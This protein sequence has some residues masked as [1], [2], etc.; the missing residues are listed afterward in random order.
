MAKRDKPKDEGTSLSPKAQGKPDALQRPTHPEPS[1]PESVKSAR[2]SDPFEAIID[3][4]L[5]ALE[6]GK[7][8]TSVLAAQHYVRILDKVLKNLAEVQV[9]VGRM[10]T[11]LSNHVK[12]LRKA[13]PIGEPPE[14]KVIKRGGKTFVYDSG[15]YI[16]IEGVTPD[17]DIDQASPE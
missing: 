4:S 7:G 2:V 12:P 14:G 16:P 5:G 13:E 8:Q 11:E 3:F 17:V 9:A 1:K 6:S 10:R 15:R